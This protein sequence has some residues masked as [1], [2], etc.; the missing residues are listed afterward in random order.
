MPRCMHRKAKNLLWKYEG[1]R[2]IKIEIEFRREIYIFGCLNVFKK[3]IKN[4][5]ES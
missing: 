4:I 1:G 5:F 2:E 3:L